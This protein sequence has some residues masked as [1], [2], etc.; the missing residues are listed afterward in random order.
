MEATKG[1]N[2]MVDIPQLPHVTNLEL[3]FRSLNNHIFG[4]CVS[5]ILARCSNLQHL[6]LGINK[7][8]IRRCGDVCCICGCVGSWKE[9]K[10]SLDHL[11]EV[12]FNGF[13]GQECHD[14]AHLLLLNSPA[15]Q[16]MSVVVEV[17]GDISWDDSS[18]DESPPCKK[19]IMETSVLTLPHP[20]GK[21]R[22]R[23]SANEATSE[24]EW[25]P[26]P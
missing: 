7:S 25:T 22:A 20:R 10:I 15:L 23:A 24:Y 3:D 13:S 5:S 8:Y 4:A 6:S 14:M 12:E 26:R 9:D 2:V 1:D 16:R 11:R 17:S 18:D 21:W 19:E